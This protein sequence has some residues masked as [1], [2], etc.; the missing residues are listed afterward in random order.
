[1]SP[2][3]VQDPE[4][5]TTVVISFN[6]AAGAVAA[7]VKRKF[8]INCYTEADT[9]RLRLDPTLTT[10]QTAGSHTGAKKIL[11]Y[12]THPH[13]L[14]SLDPINCGP[15]TTPRDRNTWVI[16]TLKVIEHFTAI[17][18]QEAAE[19]NINDMDTREG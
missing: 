6:T 19:G 7:M 10:G 3:R 14:S 5:A 2:R 11:S 1:M 4:K 8:I 16:N 18:L 12:D 13:P 9:G 17:P 15:G